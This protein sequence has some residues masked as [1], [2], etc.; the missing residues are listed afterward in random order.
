MQ[1]TINN[2]PV[3]VIG[4]IHGLF[5]KLVDQIVKNDLMDCVMISVGD[6]GIGFNSSYKDELE[7]QKKINDFLKLR[8]IMLYIIRGNHDD[9]SFFKGAGRLVFSNLE[10]LEDYTVKDINDEKFLFVG[11]ALSIDRKYRRDGISYWIDE[12][13]TLDES[14]VTECDVLITHSAPSWIGP[15]DKAGISGWCDKDP[16]LWDECLKERKDHNK[17][18]KLAK[19]KKSYCGHFHCSTVVDFDGCWATI[20]NEL[21]IKEHRK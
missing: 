17:L 19:P 18:F 2:Q 15:F 6:Y 13:F 20:L 7:T 21:E 5:V 8:N 4:D 3:F 1:E 12:V 9:P 14:Q 10:F 11:G 16:T